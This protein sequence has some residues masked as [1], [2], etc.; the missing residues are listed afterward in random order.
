MNFE[1]SRLFL[2]SLPLSFPKDLSL[3]QELAED[4]SRRELVRTWQLLMAGILKQDYRDTNGLHNL[5]QQPIP[6]SE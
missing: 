1:A 6:F 4:S 5:R 2:V 3:S